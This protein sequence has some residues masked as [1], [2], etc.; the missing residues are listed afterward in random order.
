MVC[1]R[2][3]N[4]NVNIQ[5]VTNVET[6][7]RGCFRWLMWIILACLTLGLILLIIPLATNTKTKSKNKTVAICQNCG[8]RWNV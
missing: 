6:K 3:K 4:S 7:H 1:P 5:V 8:K 2:C